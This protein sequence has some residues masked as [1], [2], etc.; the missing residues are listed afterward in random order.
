MSTSHYPRHLYG[1]YASFKI[2]AKF[3]ELHIDVTSPSPR[4]HWLRALKALSA[5]R[6]WALPFLRIYYG[7]NTFTWPLIR[8]TDYWAWFPEQ[9]ARRI[10]LLNMLLP[11]G[12]LI[13][14]KMCSR[15]KEFSEESRLAFG[16]KRCEMEYEERLR[17]LKL[18]SQHSKNTGCF[19]FSWRR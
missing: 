10:P 6:I 4:T 19:F 7:A 11:S 13:W 2:S 3:Y 5:S 1:I 14:F 15:S 12:I 17:K 18:N 16:Q 8:L 9:W